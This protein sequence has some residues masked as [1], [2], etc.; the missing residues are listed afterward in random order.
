M[1]RNESYS[2]IGELL[3]NWRALLAAFIGLAG[4]G[5]VQV[6]TTNVF[7]PSLIAEFDWSR[8]AFAMVGAVGFAGLFVVPF[9]GRLADLFGVRRTAAI[10]ISTLPLTYIAMTFMS[11][12]IYVYFALF[13]VQ[14]M[15]GATCTSAVYSRLI[16]ENFVK[17][18]GLAFAIIICGPP[19]LAA[20]GLP[21][22]SALIE[23]EGWRAGFFAAAA[24]SLVAGILALLLVPRGSSAD[25]DAA[26]GRLVAEKKRSRPSLTRDY[27]VIFRS[28]VFWL[29]LG[30]MAL[31]NIPQ[32]LTHSQLMLV[33]EDNGAKT[34]TAA[35]ALSVFAISVVFGRLCCGLALDRFPTHI[36]ATVTMGLPAVGLLILA[37]SIDATPALFL[38]IALIGLSQGAESDVAAYIVAR[39]FGLKVYG[40]VLGLVLTGIGGA[41]VLGAIILSASLDLT[42][43]YTAFLFGCALSVIL[44]SMM[45]FLLRFWRDVRHEGEAVAG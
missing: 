36:V 9:T 31:C 45:F 40:S 3:A 17:A 27:P 32:T 14:S 2:Y 1:N 38:S 44:G 33:M 19:G 13:A 22:L 41:T 5:A 43:S 29:T 18:R 24:F 21:L 42:G 37:S 16:V 28:P 12:S 7:G 35:L 11:G 34:A 23:A 8:A 20:I 39:Y 4:G 25:K 10:G 15:V 6:Y 30:G 26:A